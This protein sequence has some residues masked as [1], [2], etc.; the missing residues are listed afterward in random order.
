MLSRIPWKRIYVTRTEGSRGA[1]AA[2]VAECFRSF[3]EAE[4]ICIEQVEEAY[5][6]ALYDKDDN[7]RLLCIGS[8]YLVGEI[9]SLKDTRLHS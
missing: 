1:S 2:L 3:S 4:I 8:L 6:R 5:T 7:E 9:L